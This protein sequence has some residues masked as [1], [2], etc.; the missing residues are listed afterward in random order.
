MTR[1]TSKRRGGAVLLVTHV[2]AVIIAVTQPAGRDTHFVGTLE[3]VGSAGDRWARVVFIRC[4]LA[5][6][7][8]VT[9]PLVWYAEAVS[10][11]LELIV[12]AQAWTSSGWWGGTDSLNL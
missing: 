1:G 11:A 7:V 4:I 10:L 2:P 8:A 5:V 6:W 9:L 12:V 3:V